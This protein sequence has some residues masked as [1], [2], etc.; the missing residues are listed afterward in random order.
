MHALRVAAGKGVDVVY[1][2]IKLVDFTFA[3]LKMH[4]FPAACYASC[5]AGCNLPRSIIGGY[6]FP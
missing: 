1:E 4:N 5:N 3:T 6:S 2:P